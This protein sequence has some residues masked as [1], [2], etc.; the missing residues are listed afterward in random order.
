MMNNT[1][2]SQCK[3]PAGT[4]IIGKWNRHRYE[5][6]RMLGSG[7][8]GVVYL[9]ES[10]FGLTAIKISIDSV[11]IISEVNVLKALEK[12]QGSSLGPSLY[13]VDDW[14]NGKRRIHFY[15]M[16]YIKGKEL[17]HFV[18]EKGI[19]WA[20]IMMIQLL[21]VL[22]GLHQKGWVFGDLK[23]ENLIVEGPTPKIRCI[24]VGGTTMR[25][26]AIKEFTEF[27]DRGYWGLGSRKAEPSYDLF[28]TAMMMINLHYPK[29]FVKSGNSVKQLTI[30]IQGNKELLKFDTILM[31]AL[32]GKYDSAKE[33][34]KELLIILSAGERSKQQRTTR[35]APKPKKKKM[36]AF[37]ETVSILLITMILYTL[38]I[39]GYIL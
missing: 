34:K 30:I 25:G 19:S 23:P 18:R 28:S 29:R 9:A 22:E 32:L 13:D 6:V 10:S 11:S 38:Y 17:L 5:I 2:K 33:M 31:K 8:N 37:L 1:W 24:D 39:Y 7:A 14:E 12:V 3:Y 36:R 4:V 35:Y 20:G 16:E 15:V 26:R 21:D 27:F